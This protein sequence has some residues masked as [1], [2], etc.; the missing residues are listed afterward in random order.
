MKEYEIDLALPPQERWRFGDANRI[1]RLIAAA[2]K[3]LEAMYPTW[4]LYLVEKFVAQMMRLYADSECLEEIYG[5]AEYAGVSPERLLLLNVSYDLASHGTPLPGMLGCTGA[6]V[7]ATDG[8]AGIARNLDWSFPEVVI[9]ETVLHRFVDSRVPGWSALT[10]GFPG[11][12]G[13]VSGMNCHGVALTLNQAFHASFPRIARPMTWVVRD[14]LLDSASFDEALEILGKTTA[15][16]SGYV[17]LTGS[18]PG[19]AVILESEDNA[20]THHWLEDGDFLTWA[21]HYA[22]EE[23]PEDREWGDSHAREETLLRA[24]LRGDTPRRALSRPPVLNGNTAHQL[25]L[26]PVT[27]TIEIRCPTSNKPTWKTYSV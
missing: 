25:I 1:K 11:F 19:E 22:V 21:N 10:V 6:L 4:A 20:D 9:N 2:E 8:S 16:S 26:S 17:F 12:I 24:L 14:A 7:R 3:E 13:V 5:L 23:P 18:A 15:M 27:G